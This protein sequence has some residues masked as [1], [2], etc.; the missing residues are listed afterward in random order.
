LKCAGQI[1]LATNVFF[2]LL[3]LDEETA[4]KVR[5]NGEKQ[6]ER[7]ARSEKSGPPRKAAPTRRRRETRTRLV[8]DEGGV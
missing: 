5:R 7:P 4:E 8:G 1:S 3:A 2:T 6:E